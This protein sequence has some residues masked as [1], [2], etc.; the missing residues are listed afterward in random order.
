MQNKRIVFMGTPEISKTYL[1]TLIEN[2]FEVIGVYT[3]PP[4]KKGRGLN[5]EKSSVHQFA[6]EKK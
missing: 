1:E 4:R 2:N 6:L 5:I 3:Q